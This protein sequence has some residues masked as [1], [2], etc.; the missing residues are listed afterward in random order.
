MLPWLTQQK[1]VSVHEISRIFGISDKDVLTDLALLTFVGPDQAGGGLV[2][3]QYSKEHVKVIDNQ[4]L[5]RP[6]T[7]NE[8]EI[9][10]LLMGLRTLQDLEISNPATVTALGKLERLIKDDS[11]RDSVNNDLNSAIANN[12]VLQIQY[13]K[14]SDNSL[15]TREVEPLLIQVDGAILKLKAWCLLSSGYRTFRVDRILSTKVIDRKFVQREI[16]EEAVPPKFLISLNLDASAKWI[17]QQFGIR[18]TTEISGDI[19]IQI[20]IHSRSWLLRFLATSAFK[21]KEIELAADEKQSLVVVI[22]S[23]INRLAKQ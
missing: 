14:L 8:I 21:I 15:S 23:I 19:D 7:L 17:L 4:G 6:L 20:P 9:I 3:I 12:S 5:A 13:L 18:F 11:L 16:T 1:K 22:D 10:S 2:D